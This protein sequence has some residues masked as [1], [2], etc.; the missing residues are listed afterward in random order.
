MAVDGSS[1]PPVLAKRDHEGDI[2]MSHFSPENASRTISLSH[3][4]TPGLTCGVSRKE[5]VI[6]DVRVILCRMRLENGCKAPKENSN[7]SMSE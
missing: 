7:H 2:E 4:L 3:H 1:S 5:R 6:Y